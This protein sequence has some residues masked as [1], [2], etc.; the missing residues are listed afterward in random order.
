MAVIYGSMRKAM[1]KEHSKM[2][3]IC[4]R[5]QK[6]EEMIEQMH[7]MLLHILNRD[8]AYRTHTQPYECY[9]SAS[10]SRNGHGGDKRIQSKKWLENEGDDIIDEGRSPLLKKFQAQLSV[11]QA[12]ICK[13]SRM[14]WIEDLDTDEVI[15][16]V[17]S[18]SEK[19]IELLTLVIVD[20]FKQT[21][22]AEMWG[23]SDTAI[24]K[25]MKKIRMS[26]EK[27]LPEGLKKKYIG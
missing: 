17:K 2:A 19:N 9:D 7:D 25:R 22:V 18:Q 14:S 8:R 26:L 12:E 15:L 5:E 6:S 11:T 3:V 27:V 1:E 23:V 13:W 16:W 4:R 20:G 10:K 24:S 21:E